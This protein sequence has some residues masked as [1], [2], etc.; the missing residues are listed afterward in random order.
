MPSTNGFSSDF[1]RVQA[2][3]EWLIRRLEA[4][5]ARLLALE[6]RMTRTGKRPQSRA[7]VPTV[8]AAEARRARSSSTAGARRTR[9]R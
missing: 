2:R 1:A 3:V 8:K 9:R 6:L 5:D 4:L 7:T